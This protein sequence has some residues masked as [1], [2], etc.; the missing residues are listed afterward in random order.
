MAPFFWPLLKNQLN[1]IKGIVQKKLRWI[2]SGVNRWVM[3]Q[4]WGAWHYFLI[5]KRL[6]LVFS[7]KR[8]PKFEPKLLVMW[9][10]FGEALKIVYSTYH[11]ANIVLAPLLLALNGSSAIPWCAAHTLA[12]VL[13]VLDNVQHF[14]HHLYRFTSLPNITNNLD[15]S[16]GKMFFVKS[17]M[18]SL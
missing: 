13:L 17:K 5:W 11:F 16:G 9:E 15:L 4:Y 7:I 6:H 3:L 12:P 18:V 10:G 1:V 2:E 8:L 14:T